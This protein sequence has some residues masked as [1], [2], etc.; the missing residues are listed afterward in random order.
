MWSTGMRKR[1]EVYGRIL[2]VL[3]PEAEDESSEFAAGLD[4]CW[5]GRAFHTFYASTLLV[6]S[7]VRADALESGST[8]P[9]F[10]A[11]AVA[12]PELDVVSRATALAA[13]APERSGFWERIRTH[14]VQT[15]E[16][17]RALVWLWPLAMLGGSDGERPFA[18]VD[19]GA[20]AGLNLVADSMSNIWTDEDD[21]PIDVVSAPIAHARVGLDRAPLDAASEESALWLRACVW[22]GQTDRQDRVEEA[23]ATWRRLRKND[24][25]GTP[26]VRTGDLIGAAELARDVAASCPAD[27]LTVAYQSIVR[28][29]LD[30]ET[31]SAYED[32]MLGWIAESDPGRS[33]WLEFEPTDHLGAGFAVG[34]TAHFRSR[35]EDGSA[36]DV[37]QLELGRCD[38]HPRVLAPSPQ[39]I[40]EFVA[41]FS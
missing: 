7:S 6:L 18:L 37:T 26:S 8:H 27:T 29:Y 22:P 30:P 40:T 4:D 32:S 12:Q 24:P 41:A 15:N 17:S 23:I 13:V 31:N 33:L 21:Q 19:V 2:D 11:I 10:S 20:S 5:S 16:T 3:I 25:D 36:G 38:Y 14:A 1:V 34:I 9:L 28:E 35:N 39:A